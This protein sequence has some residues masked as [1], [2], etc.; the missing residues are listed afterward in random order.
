MR[1][2]TAEQL[3]APLLRT[4]LSQ[5][6]SESATIRLKGPVARSPWSKI[7]LGDGS[8]FENPI[9][10]K[11]CTDPATGAPA[12]E[13]A[14][15]AY[16][17]LERF[18]QLASGDPVLRCPEPLYVFP[19]EGIVVAEWIDGPN[20]EKVFARASAAEAVE[21]ARQ[22]GNWLGRLQHLTEL[23]SAPLPVAAL[24]QGLDEVYRANRRAFRTV[25]RKATMD[26][27]RRTAD[28]I[29]EQDVLWTSSYGD[30]KPANLIWRERRL[31]GLDMNAGPPGPAIGDV[32]H[33]LNHTATTI[34]PTGLFVPLTGRLERAF[35]DGYALDGGRELPE[36]PLAWTRLANAVRLR[37]NAG[38]WSRPPRLWIT[39]WMLD[40]LLSRLTAE[41]SNLAD[42]QA[43]ITAL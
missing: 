23:H 22:A 35:C 29:A 2:A 19:E 7:Y 14:I 15:D 10:V 40:R 17:A 25:I 32:A 21:A 38:S 11:V 27:L 36:L 30:F 43:R 31:Y 41:V 20:L 28:I 42:A 6:V 1:A 33:F 13:V 3:S 34:S 26:V 12:S 16:N 24:L 8:A 4:L 5:S 9:V 18:A 37:A 39:N